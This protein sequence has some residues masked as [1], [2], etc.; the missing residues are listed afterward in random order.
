MLTVK[1]N[2]KWLGN[3]GE[4]IACGYLQAKGYRVI[5]TNI[6]VGRGELDIICKTHNTL[7]FVEVKSGK[8]SPYFK[9][10]EHFNYTKAMQVRQL[11]KLYLNGRRLFDVDARIDLIAITFDNETSWHIEHFENVI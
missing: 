5:A 2:S 9:P 10:Q 11:A 6:R 3:K 4:T 7:T 8:R 1:Q